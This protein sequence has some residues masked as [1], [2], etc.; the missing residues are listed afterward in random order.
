MVDDD[1][2]AAILARR[3]RGESI[4]TIAAGAKVSIGVVRK[5]LEDTQPPAGVWFAPVSRISSSNLHLSSR[6]AALRH[7]ARC[8]GDP[9]GRGATPP[10]R[11]SNRRSRRAR[12]S[13][14]MVSAGSPA[15]RRRAVSTSTVV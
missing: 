3:Q 9:H 5:A 12:W 4:R 10:L 6:R 7:R 11:A 2:R 14:A 1:K 8:G 15:I 13:S